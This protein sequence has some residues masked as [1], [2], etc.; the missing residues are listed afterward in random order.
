[1]IIF[2]S[3]QGTQTGALQ[4]ITDAFGGIQS[5]ILFPLEGRRS[6]ATGAA[7]IFSAVARID[8]YG[9]EIPFGSTP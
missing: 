6:P 7:V 9:G 1:M 4:L 8:Q 3:H 5:E 2:T